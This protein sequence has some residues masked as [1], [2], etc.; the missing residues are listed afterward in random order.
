[1]QTMSKSQTRPD[2]QALLSICHDLRSDTSRLS[3]HILP[4][5]DARRTFVSKLSDSADLP[6]ILLD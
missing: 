2:Q 6:H 4:R 1:M 5:V 3:Q